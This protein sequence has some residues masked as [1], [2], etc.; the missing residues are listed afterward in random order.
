MFATAAEGPKIHLTSRHEVLT[1]ALRRR[2]EEGLK[3][4]SKLMGKLREA[5]VILNFENKQH[6]CEVNLYGKNLKLSAK[7]FSYDMYS[8]IDAALAKLARQVRKTKAK[9]VDRRR[10]GSPRSVE[11]VVHG[12]IAPFEEGEEVRVIRSRSHAIKPMSVEEAV[13]QLEGSRDEFLVFRNAE[14][15]KTNVV[16]KRSDKHIGLIEPED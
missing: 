13:L 6:T 8:S 14:S 15:G 10:Q 5:H 7:G 1:P 2:V 4:A 11:K 3:R 16:Y 9:R 12:L